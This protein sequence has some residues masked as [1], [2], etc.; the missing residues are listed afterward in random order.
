MLNELYRIE[1]EFGAII[2][3]EKGDKRILSFDSDLQQ[4]CVY[5]HQPHV[6]VHEYTQIMLLSLL[7]VEAKNVTVLGLGGGSLAH[8]LNFYFPKLVTHV[9]EI[10]P[11]VIDVAYQWFNLPR[12]ANL[13]VH[14][15]DA[16]HYILKAK[17]HSIDL[18]LS[19]LYEANGMS[20][21][22]AQN[23]FIVSSVKALALDGW[24]VINFHGKPENDSII[25]S[26]IKSLFSEIMFCDVF[27]GNWIL[28]CGNKKAHDDSYELNEQVRCLAKKV[29]LPLLYYFKQIKSVD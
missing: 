14:C 2:V 20:E 15:D 16:G 4:S 11:S 29:D 21:V 9:V 28:F 23:N 27:V 19:D 26:T 10:R 1:D 7:F 24:M 12:K 5:M 3:L 17:Q 18:L 6:L 25:M 22:Q 13:K 8:C